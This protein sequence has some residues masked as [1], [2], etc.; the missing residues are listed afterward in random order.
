MTL[1]YKHYYAEKKDIK[2]R[3]YGISR[4]ERNAK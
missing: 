3:D 1:E 2:V 4:K